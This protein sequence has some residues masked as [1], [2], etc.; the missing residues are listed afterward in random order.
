M[1][2]SGRTRRWSRRFRGA[3]PGIPFLAVALLLGVADARAVK[4]EVIK[5]FQEE[6]AGH[7]YRLRV[8]LQGTNYLAA[9][10][11]VNDAGFAYRGR[12]FPVLFHQLEMVYLDRVSNDGNQAVGLTIYRSKDDAGQIR[13][14]L[15]P[16]PF[17]PGQQSTESMLGS[18]ARGFSTSVTLELKS[19]KKDIPGQR[20]EIRRLLDQVFY[21]K[22]EPTEQEKES[23]VLSHPDYPIPKLMERTGLP[24][25]MIRSILEHQRGEK[26]GE[27]DEKKP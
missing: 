14:A 8:D 22:Q 23:F 9:P 3:L 13:G 20:D 21:I 24:E 2:F 11:V 5:D 15:S 26:A 25:A 17:G 10:N 19:D 18:Y 4:R 16:A 7:S 27:T 12:Q 6:F 1:N